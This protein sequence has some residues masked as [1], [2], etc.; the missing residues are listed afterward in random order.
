MVGN[1]PSTWLIAESSQRGSIQPLRM[2]N[3]TTTGG[4][5]CG[6]RNAVC[7]DRV[8]QVF[9]QTAYLKT[10]FPSLCLCQCLCLC[11]CPRRHSELS[12][13]CGSHS[14]HTRLVCRPVESF[15]RWSLMLLITSRP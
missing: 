9:I 3:T 8:D 6:R 7:I 2:K 11:L 1:P 10:K 5:P 15:A 12:W 4:L 13:C 14:K